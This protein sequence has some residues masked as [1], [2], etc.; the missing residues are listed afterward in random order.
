VRE[1]GAEPE[2]KVFIDKS[3]AAAVSLPMIR[4][5]FPQA[6][7]LIAR[8]DPRDV[9]L[10]CFRHHFVMNPITYEL[11]DLVRA[12]RHY[13]ALMRL[14]ELY[15]AGLPISARVVRYPDLIA[16]FDK[17]TRKVCD[18]IGVEW[19]DKVR[20]FART[21]ARRNVKSSSAK[22]VLRPLYSGSDQWLRY[23]DQLEAVLPVLEPWVER[24][25]FEPTDPQ[26]DFRPPA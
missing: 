15:L 20:D 6:R 12:A 3:P 18:F 1:H 17:E 7:I 8:R 26:L 24:F 11:T 22:Q 13:D 23:R 5:L 19:S 14:T 4:K 21:A 9:V 2:G 10:S 16:D 25:G